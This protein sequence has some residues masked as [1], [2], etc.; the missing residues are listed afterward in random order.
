MDTDVIR[1]AMPYYV[2]AVAAFGTAAMCIVAAAK[3][4]RPPW[5]LLLAFG[6][7]LLGAAFFLIA[8]T[9]APGGHV[10]RTQVSTLIRSLCL[11]G[12]LFWIAWLLLF[13][14]SVVR[15][16]KRRPAGE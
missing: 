15:V 6:F 9:A 10:M 2:C 4:L 13:A 3:R 5:V 11:L 12:G 1:L 16:E 8:A 7:L 14:R